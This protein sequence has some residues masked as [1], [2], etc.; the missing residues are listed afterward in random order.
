[1]AVSTKFATLSAAI[2]QIKPVEIRGTVTSATGLELMGEGLSSA[3]SIGAQV[4]VAGRIRG[5]VVGFSGRLCRILPFGNW[6]GVAAGDEIL[7]LGEETSIRPSEAWL[8]RI[9]DPFGNPLDN[10]P[11]LAGREAYRIRNDPPPAFN[12][13]PVGEKMECGVKALDI[14]VPICRGQRLGIFAGSG[15]GKSTLMGML[16]RQAEADVIVIGLVGERGKE[17]QGFIKKELGAEGLARSVLVVATSD[18]PS[19]TR[20]QAAWTATAVAEFFRDQGKHVLLMLDSVTRFA[21]AQREIGLA[22]GE[23]SITKGYTPTVLTE[24][25]RLLERAGPGNPEK[26][27]GDISAIF[28][29]LVDGDDMNEIIAD[30]ARGI[31]DGHIV[32]DRKIAEAGRYP[33][34]D[35]LKSVSRELP[36]CHAPAERAILG[37]SKRALGRHAD[38]EELVRIGAYRRGADPETDMAISFAATAEEFLRQGIKAPV[39]SAEGFAQLYGLLAEAGY[40]ITQEELTAS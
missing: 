6:E 39:S 31:L 33:A 24:L 4:L 21:M 26:G 28:T 14:F 3:A 37:R 8:G 17:V 1:M 32:L 12:R 34:I 36:H 9:I 11:A 22:A 19:L 35:V 10:K 38:M 30:T 40:E 23:P 13:R 29:V 15:V 2:R 25:P 20:R 16:A 7:V 18:Q 27:Q 5:E